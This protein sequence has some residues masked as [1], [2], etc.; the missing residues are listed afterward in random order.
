MQ[1]LVPARIT[2][3]IIDLKCGLSFSVRLDERAL[4]RGQD[5]LDPNPAGYGRV[6]PGNWDEE[7]DKGSRSPGFDF[8]TRAEAGQSQSKDQRRHQVSNNSYVTR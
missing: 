2:P 4:G 3:T 8:E 5:G 6:E 1:T 7:R